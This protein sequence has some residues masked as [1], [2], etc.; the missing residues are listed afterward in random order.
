MGSNKDIDLELQGAG[1]KLYPLHNLAFMSNT[2]NYILIFCYFISICQ[3][4]NVEI[5]SGLEIWCV[6]NLRLV[7]VPQSSHGKFFS[8][9]AYVVLNVSQP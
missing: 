3:V 9:S 1:S 2:F 8:G 5:Y 6:E 4:L 7:S